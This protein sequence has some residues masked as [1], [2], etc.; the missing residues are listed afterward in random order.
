MYPIANTDKA[1]IMKSKTNCNKNECSQVAPKVN[2]AIEIDIPARVI[3]SMV[4]CSP[5]YVKLIRQGK[6][7][8]YTKTA[9]RI[10]VVDTLLK[11]GIRDLIVNTKELIQKAS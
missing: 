8:G 6:R 10:Q 9:E 1:N 5:I 2:E 4:G 7:E 3:A 11:D